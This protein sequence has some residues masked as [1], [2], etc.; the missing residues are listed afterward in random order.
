[1][2]TWLRDLDQILRGDATKPSMLRRGTIEL[3]VR[4][5]SIGILILGMFYGMC[6]ALFAL[7]RQDGP[8][9]AQIAAA[10][11][12]VPLLLFLTLAVTFP[13]LYVFNA[14]VG[15]RLSALSLLRLLSA[16]LGVII[17]LLG[18]FALIV[19]FFSVSSKSYPFMLLLNV[20]VFSIAGT[21]GL[22]FLLQ[23]LHR[24]N[25]ALEATALEAPASTDRM[26]A[27]AEVAA[28][29]DVPAPTGAAEVP[30]PPVLPFAV[31]PAGALQ[32]IPGTTVGSGVR[33]VFRIWVIVFALVGAQMSW[34][35]RPFIG[36]PDRPFAWFRGRESNFFEAVFYTIRTLLS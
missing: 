31:A 10:M 1:M 22:R 25:L 28:A 3:P 30:P 20:A 5:V 11:V 8:H 2:W 17:S 12:K 23:T 29:A 14:L 13:S 24:L 6:M 9:Y 19:A 35:L 18:G 16:A 27:E 36:A 4:S 7:F 34:V 32:P 21:Y 33:T 26:A 15:S